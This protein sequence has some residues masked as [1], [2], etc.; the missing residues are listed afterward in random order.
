MNPMSSHHTSTQTNKKKQ[1]KVSENKRI[2]Y[3]SSDETFPQPSKTG[4]RHPPN[5]SSPN[6][7][8]SRSDIVTTVTI[9]NLYPG[10]AAVVGK[11][12]KDS[13]EK[14][15]SQSSCA[16]TGAK[17]ITTA[18]IKPLSLSSSSTKNSKL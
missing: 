1:V 12:D 15:V 2:R 10:S 3:F 7:P 18:T 16:G 13:K 9:T 14:D 6:S 8:S 17:T 11:D 5:P 4:N